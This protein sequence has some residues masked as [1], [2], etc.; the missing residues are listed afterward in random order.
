MTRGTIKENLVFGSR[1][2]I[3]RTAPG[4]RQTVTLKD[5]PYYVHVYVRVDGLGGVV[6][7]DEDYPQRV[8]I[9]LIYKTLQT[10]D[11]QTQGKWTQVKQD[12]TLEPKFMSADLE[13]FQDPKNDT[14]VKIQKDLDEIK[15]VMHNNIEQILK[16]GETMEALVDKSNDLSN[17]SKQFHKKAKAANSC[18]RSW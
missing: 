9:G 8:A 17:S 10:F 18:C 6:I 13:K 14:I 4:N 11:A 15:E 12:Q 7:S 1:T 3:Q 2:C 16:N 5:V